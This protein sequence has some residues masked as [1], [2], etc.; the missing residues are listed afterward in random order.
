MSVLAKK[1]PTSEGLS[2]QKNKGELKEEAV[3][4]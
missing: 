3:S 1:S 4:S 2:N